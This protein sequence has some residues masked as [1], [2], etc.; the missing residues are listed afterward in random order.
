ML[1]WLCYILD[2]LHHNRECRGA[3]V[4]FTLYLQQ[5]A[6]VSERWFGIATMHTSAIAVTTSLIARSADPCLRALRMADQLDSLSVH[7]LQS[8]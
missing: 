6:P 3:S 4:H 8:R 2:E 1:S 7:L 5:S